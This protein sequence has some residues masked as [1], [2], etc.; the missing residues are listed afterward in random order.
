MEV[1]S[2][3]LKLRQCTFSSL[4]A[5][6]LAALTPHT[7]RMMQTR[8]KDA[9]W[10]HASLLSWQAVTAMLIVTFLELRER[11]FWTNGAFSVPTLLLPS[12]KTV[13]RRVLSLFRSSQV[14]SDF[15]SQTSNASLWPRTSSLR[16][17]SLVAVLH[18]RFGTRLCLGL[19]FSLVRSPASIAVT[20]AASL[21]YALKLNSRKKPGSV[22][23][24]TEDI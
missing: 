22:Q 23:N 17:S 14:S 20:E 10:N 3:L 8:G 24:P 9:P 21:S 11:P 5:P 15:M 6:I 16:L 2:A 4:K 13:A 19:H 12:L 18:E 7:S 1:N